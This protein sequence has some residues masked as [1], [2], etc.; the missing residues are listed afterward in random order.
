MV[1]GCSFSR[2]RSIP[3]H[4]GR[5]IHSVV[6]GHL[7]CFQLSGYKPDVLLLVLE[8]L[9]FACVEN[10][11][12]SPWPCASCTRTCTLEPLL[13]QSHFFTASSV[14]TES[15]A[16]RAN[17]LSAR[18][19]G[20]GLFLSRSESIISKPLASYSA[21]SRLKSESPE[22]RVPSWLPAARGFYSELTTRP[23]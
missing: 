21:A 13:T 23:N 4:L 11:I 2:L 14:S 7:S 18:L 6:D 9:C 20:A 12:S 19:G 8:G 5:F 17:P 22:I 15:G 3:P 1:G 16:R 10:R